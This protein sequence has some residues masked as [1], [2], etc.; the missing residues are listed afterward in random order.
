MSGSD[1]AA[2]ATRGEATSGQQQ[3]PQQPWG[4]ADARAAL[5]AS[6]LSSQLHCR[7]PLLNTGEFQLELDEPGLKRV[8]G[9]PCPLEVAEPRQVVDEDARATVESAGQSPVVGASA[10][11]V[12]FEVDPGHAQPR[13]NGVIDV[14]DELSGA[15]GLARFYEE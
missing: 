14:D 6:H 15:I 3:R 10:S 2:S 12:H 13:P 11:A 9:L 8:V 5:A 4:H 1:V 7:R